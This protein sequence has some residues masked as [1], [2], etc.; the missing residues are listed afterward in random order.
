M[1]LDGSDEDGLLERP[2]C[3]LGHLAIGRG[4]VLAWP[5]LGTP[6]RDETH[7]RRSSTDRS[8]R[9][10]KSLWPSDKGARM[11]ISGVRGNCFW[12]KCVLP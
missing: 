11:L 5:S 6:N 9:G 4:A 1:L 10:E 3:P 12:N 2:C 7:M 8:A